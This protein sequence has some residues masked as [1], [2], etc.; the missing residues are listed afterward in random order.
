MPKLSEYK[1]LEDVLSTEDAEALLNGVN[2]GVPLKPKLTIDGIWCDRDC[3]YVK[4]I[5]GNCSTAYSCEL[6]G[7]E[8]SYYDGPVAICGMS[9]YQKHRGPSSINSRIKEVFDECQVYTDD[10]NPEATYRE[11]EFFA[12]Q[13]IKECCNVLRPELRD[14]VS[15]GQAVDMIKRHFGVEESCDMPQECKNEISEIPIAYSTD[16]LKEW[17]KQVIMQEEYYDVND[18]DVED[19]K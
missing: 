8:L 9:S 19:Q 16:E 15:R 5:D 10:L 6:L 12:E 13:I 11:I 18:D 1:D 17:D 7:V 4:A 3:P 2:P 14:M